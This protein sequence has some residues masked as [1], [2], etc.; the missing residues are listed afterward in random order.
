MIRTVPKAGVSPQQPMSIMKK[1]IALTSFCL[2]FSALCVSSR[3][4]DREIGGI[5]R[6][7]GRPLRPQRLEFRQE[8]PR[9]AKPSAATAGRKCSITGPSHLSLI[10]TTSISSTKWISRTSRPTA[11]L[12]TF[13]PIKARPRAWTCGTFRVTGTWAHGNGDLEFLIIESCSR[14]WL[15]AP[16]APASGDWWTPWSTLF[17]GLH[18][19]CGFRTLSYSDNGIP[20][21]YA[22]KLKANGGVWQSWFS[23]VDGERTLR[24]T[25]GRTPS[26]RGFAC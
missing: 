22:N 12:T 18:Q 7:G 20:N 4:A 2:I 5:R 26:F 1:H 15:S 16:E 14:P 8:L 19:L 11:R 9:L 25:T 17:H 3:A 21:R 23:A 10:P 6:P 13:K 24:P